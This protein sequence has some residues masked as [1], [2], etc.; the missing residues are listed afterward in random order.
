M[1]IY[2]NVNSSITFFARSCLVKTPLAVLWIAT[3]PLFHLHKKIGDG[4]KL[5][6]LKI[7]TSYSWH[8]AIT[9]Q[10]N[11]CG[12]RFGHMMDGRRLNARDHEEF[13]W[14]IGEIYHSA[15]ASLGKIQIN[16]Q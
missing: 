13:F 1:E 16:D 12:V 5:S 9:G 11:L 14:G 10:Q 4:E 7:F 8:F 6:A 3:H 2:L 15:S